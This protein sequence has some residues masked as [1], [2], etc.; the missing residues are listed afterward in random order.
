MSDDD[1]LIRVTIV[2]CCEI[3]NVECLLF[4]LLA[5]LSTKTSP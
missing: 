4:S 1:G 3:H 2:S 5:N